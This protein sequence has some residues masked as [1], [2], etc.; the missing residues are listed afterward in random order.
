MEDDSSKMLLPPS[1]IPGAE[2]SK[3]WKQHP[4]VR[5]PSMVAFMQRY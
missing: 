5:S 1:D 4:M 3:P 2:L